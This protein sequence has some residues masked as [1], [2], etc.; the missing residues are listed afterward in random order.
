M[1]YCESDSSLFQRC[2]NQLQLD[3]Q[4]D[5]REQC[6]YT[7]IVEVTDD[8]KKKDV[9]IVIMQRTTCLSAEA[10]ND[11][12]K[13]GRLRPKSTRQMQNR[14]RTSASNKN[15]QI[16]QVRGFLFGRELYKTLCADDYIYK[17]TI[18][19]QHDDSGEDIHLLHLGSQFWFKS[20]R[21]RVRGQV[22]ERTNDIDTEPEVRV[23]FRLLVPEDIPPKLEWS[24]WFTLKS[25]RD[26]YYFPKNLM[27]LPVH[28][29][30]HKQPA[31]CYM[32]YTSKDN[33]VQYRG[34]DVQL[35]KG[36]ESLRGTIAEFY[37]A[38]MSLNQFINQKYKLFD[39]DFNVL[40][41]DTI[42]MKPLKLPCEKRA[43]VM[44]EDD[45]LEDDVLTT[46]L[47]KIEFKIGAPGESSP[48]C[49][50]WT[51]DEVLA[52]LSAGFKIAH[53]TLPIP[54]DFRA[55]FFEFFAGTCGLSAEFAKR[56]VKTYPMDVLLRSGDTWEY[57]AEKNIGRSSFDQLKMEFF[58]R[59]R[60]TIDSGIPTDKVMVYFGIPCKYWNTMQNRNNMSRTRAN[61]ARHRAS[62]DIGQGGPW[63]IT[64]RPTRRDEGGVTRAQEE[65]ANWQL[66]A[67]VDLID[68]MCK[69]F[70]GIRYCF[71]HG[72]STYLWD[73]LA[74]LKARRARLSKPIGVEFEPVL[75]VAACRC[76]AVW[77]KETR[78]ASNCPGLKEAFCDRK[79]ECKCRAHSEDRG[80]LLDGHVQINGLGGGL[81][82]FDSAAYPTKLCEVFA[83]AVIKGWLQP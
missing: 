44:L 28:F 77:M 43:R 20:N 25:L 59:V 49:T 47:F 4:R 38:G 29:N 10:W 40:R 16:P 75:M 31:N 15:C 41:R 70:E 78:F 61:E 82:T 19:Y 52:N 71:E 42:G 65:E 34:M 50:L 72:A 1:N 5:R 14:L 39:L 67:M 74:D 6:G 60:R 7:Y 9:G 54:A 30:P 66:I 48:V 23:I 22:I 12:Y 26:E 73:A 64:E 33:I 63:G 56:S 83:D 13:D 80:G 37:E 58:Q 53:P 45:E 68:E 36:Q 57:D 32:S 35:K 8:P 17:D 76:A 24:T 3:S 62:T 18:P 21:F 11:I 81:T 79:W 46:A 2:C 55:A 51:L 69:K 27:D